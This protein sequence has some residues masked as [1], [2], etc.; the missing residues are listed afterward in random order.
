[1]SD[2][3][4]ERLG[5]KYAATVIIFAFP[6]IFFAVAECFIARLFG[7]LF[8][9]S[10]TSFEQ[11]HFFMDNRGDV[12]EDETKRGDREREV[13]D[14]F[15]SKMKTSFFYYSRITRVTI[16]IDGRR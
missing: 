13:S 12:R 4:N 5:K 3:R 14:P 10:M 15:R 6:D 1:M 11:T 2:S 9:A 8:S 16:L 7:E